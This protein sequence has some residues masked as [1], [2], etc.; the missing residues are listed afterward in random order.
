MQCS[1]RCQPGVLML[2]CVR[3]SMRCFLN[4]EVEWSPFDE[5]RLAVAT[6]QN[7]G[8][9]GQG[10]QYVLQMKNGLLQPTATFETAVSGDTQA[11]RLG[12]ARRLECATWQRSVIR[13]APHPLSSRLCA[14]CLLCVCRMVCTTAPGLSPS[15][16]IWHSHSATAPSMSVARRSVAAD[17]QH[18]VDFIVR[19]ACACKRVTSHLRIHCACS[20]IG[21]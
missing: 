12:M 20:A 5:S 13:I 7:F 18:T 11:E 6:A 4:V 16:H 21:V 19:C 8:I 9:V 1:D 14:R 3:L 10:K 2:I 15:T 17:A